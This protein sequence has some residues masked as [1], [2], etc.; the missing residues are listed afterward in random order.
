MGRNY[1]RART[2]RGEKGESGPGLVTPPGKN[3]G[4]I[5][6]Q[7]R[8]WNPERKCGRWPRNTWGWRSEQVK[9][10]WTHVAVVRLKEKYDKSI[11]NIN[12]NISFWDNIKLKVKP[13]SSTRWRCKDYL[14]HVL[15][16]MVNHTKSS[17]WACWW[18]DRRSRARFQLQTTTKTFET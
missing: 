6:Q 16:V 7:A 12:I 15:V 3:K 4:A 1:T 8:A 11:I 9:R 10:E 5:V 18:N 17:V 13:L 2:S 14:L